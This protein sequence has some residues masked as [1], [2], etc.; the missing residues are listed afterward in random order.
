MKYQNSLSVRRPAIGYGEFIIGHLID[1]P[2]RLS[3]QTDDTNSDE[4]GLF[5]PIPPVIDDFLP[6]G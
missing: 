6:V 3:V 5:I 2:G 4:S 1:R